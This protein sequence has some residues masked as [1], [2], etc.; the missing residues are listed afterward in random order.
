MGEGE[1]A[2]L[3][4][5]RVRGEFPALAGRTFLNTATMGQLP[6]A[7]VE[8]VARHFA[9]RQ[10]DAAQ[11]APGWFDDLDRLRE[12]LGRV[13]NGKQEDI[14]LIPSSSHGLAVVLHGLEWRA[15]DRVVTLHGEF[16]NNTYAPQMMMGVEYVEARP[17]ELGEAL[18]ERTRVV[19][20]SALNYATGM[21]APLEEIRERCP[22]ALLYVDGTQGCG[23]VE[24]DV[25]KL[26]IDVLSVHGYKWMLSPTGAGFLY[27][28]AAAREKLKP[29][30]VG[31]R[32]HREWRDWANLHH[33]APE[34]A[35]TAERYEGYFPAVPLYAAME[36]SVDLLLELGVKRVEARVLELAGELREVVEAA[37]GEVLHVGS[38]IA[39]CRFGWME[40]G[41]VARRLAERGVV[42]SARQGRVRVS[43]QYYN[44]AEDLARLGEAL[45][46]MRA[47]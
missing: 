24:L 7:A 16:P 40:A 11:S 15:G 32:S 13:V 18:N 22:Q 39:A 21:R 27:V 19:V 46:E 6:R 45:R 26:G 34:L 35:E 36:A 12:K 20:V 29:H 31:W 38:P 5:R 28:N 37:G 14:A 4:W 25:E 9:L 10:A 1:A 23:A 41:E 3:D 17:E 47:A 42:V 8:A 30:V 2:G 33:G 43:V 44:D